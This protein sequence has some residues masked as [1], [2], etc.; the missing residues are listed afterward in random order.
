MKFAPAAIA[1]AGSARP[2]P[3]GLGTGRAHAAVVLRET[4]ARCAIGRMPITSPSYPRTS[5]SRSGPRY[6][7]AG[8]GWHRAFD[9]PMPPNGRRLA[10]LRDAATFITRSGAE[11]RPL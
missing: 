1:A 3:T 11:A 7:I 2:V 5:G 6:S 4:L 8:K 10:K 9:D